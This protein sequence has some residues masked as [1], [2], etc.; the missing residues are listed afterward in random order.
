MQSII[1]SNFVL[2]NI[3]DCETNHTINS[4]SVIINSKSFICCQNMLY[5]SSSFC[6]FIDHHYECDLHKVKQI[7]VQETLNYFESTAS[8]ISNLKMSK[9]A[10]CVVAATAS[11]FVGQN[12]LLTFCGRL[13][14]FLMVNLW[15]QIDMLIQNLF[16]S[17]RVAKMMLTELSTLR[18]MP[19]RISTSW[20]HLFRD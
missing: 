19:P 7:I 8:K 9:F 11:L 3:D 17:W 2:L 16:R 4:K 10:A 14:Q 6:F 1:S 5:L 15:I 20:T 13:D 12:Y 18:T